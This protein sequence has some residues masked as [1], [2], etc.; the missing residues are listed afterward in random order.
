[1]P[2]NEI[3]K[4]NIIFN[5]N[6]Q[7]NRQLIEKSFGFVNLLFC[8]SYYYATSIPQAFEFL[9]PIE[10]DENWESRLGVHRKRNEWQVKQQKRKDRKRNGGS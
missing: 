2:G 6:K 3:I 10:D 9:Y 4:Q 1:M 8:V 5:K 7:L